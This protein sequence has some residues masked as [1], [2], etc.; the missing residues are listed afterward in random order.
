MVRWDALVVVPAQRVFSS[1]PHSLHIVELK[2]LVFALTLS[3]QVE[4]KIFPD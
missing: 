3:L 4:L 2:L 1:A